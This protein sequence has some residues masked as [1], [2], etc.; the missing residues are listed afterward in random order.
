MLRLNE[1]P[2]D[3]LEYISSYLAGSHRPSLS[4]FGVVSKS[5][6]SAAAPLLFGTIHLKARTS[7]QLRVDV[8]RWTETLA[9][10]PTARHVRQLLITGFM[11]WEPT[12]EDDRNLDERGWFLDRRFDGYEDALGPVALERGTH[13]PRDHPVP[14][15]AEA[16]LAWKPVADLL[17][18]LPSLSRL[19]YDSPEQLAPCLLTALRSYHPRCRLEMLKFRF[20][21]PLDQPVDPHEWAII[22]S[23]CLHRLEVKHVA[24][25]A[26]GEDYHWEA[27]QRV[28]AGLAPNLKELKMMQC[29]A[30]WTRT[31]QNTRTINYAVNSS[32]VTSERTESWPGFSGVLDETR[33]G[34]LTSLCIT[35]PSTLDAMALGSWLSC[36]NFAMLRCLRLAGHGQTVDKNLLEWMGENLRLPG[37]KE[38][39]IEMERSMPEADGTFT[40]EDDFSQAAVVFLE[41]LPPLV[42]LSLSG[43]ITEQ[44]FDSILRHHGSGLTKLTLAPDCVWD[45]FRMPIQFNQDHIL[46]MGSNCP[47]LEELNITVLRQ[48]SR[49]KETG[50]YRAIG[51]MK[52]LVTATIA[53]DCTRPWDLEEPPEEGNRIYVAPIPPQFD[54]FDRTIVEGHSAYR[55]GHVREMIMNFAVDEDLAISIWTLIATEQ[56]NGC[57]QSL[58]LL[59]KKWNWRVSLLDQ[60]EVHMA[61][62][63]Q[64]ERNPRGAS[65]PLVRELAKNGREAR[66]KLLEELEDAKGGHFRVKGWGP[67]AL[68][69][70]VRRVWPRQAWNRDVPGRLWPPKDPRYQ[71]WRSNWSSIPLSM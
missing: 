38:L 39:D 15:T 3:I 8:A 59:T 24:A 48:V 41:T 31:S 11:A 12:S 52:N 30:Y 63:Y 35:S 55:Y 68:L 14:V 70:I 42:A 10:N 58:K 17:E 4:A 51:Q 27:I 56:G 1:L 18:A 6:R 67:D 9:Q 5:C 19:T 40:T 49:P 57:I 69:A 21:R 23:P 37:L 53:L 33:L 20:T 43:C 64:L 45:R 66:E 16:N 65:T 60:V 54:D 36:T 13:L 62:S 26:L 29:A 32:L 28:V 50:I 44:I 47:W 71:D 34:S 61:R 2:N 25:T 7:E 22:T 46:R